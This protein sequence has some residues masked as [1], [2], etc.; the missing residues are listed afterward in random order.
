MTAKKRRADEQRQ[1]RQ[2]EVVPERLAAHHGESDAE[3][4][5]TPEH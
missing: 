4:E 2:S 3:R 1:R 5:E